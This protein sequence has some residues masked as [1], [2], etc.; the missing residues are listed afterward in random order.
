MIADKVWLALARGDLAD[1]VFMAYRAVEE[2]VRKA[3]GYGDSEIGVELMRKAF[4]PKGGPLTD[5]KQEKGEREA[6]SHMF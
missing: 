5:M 1:A 4:D 2:A 3:G 6:L